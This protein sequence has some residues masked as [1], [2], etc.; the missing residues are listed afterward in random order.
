LKAWSIETEERRKKTK[1]ERA[2]VRVRWEGRKPPGE[3][4]EY[5]WR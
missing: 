5:Y 4:K 1:R 2:K 3:K